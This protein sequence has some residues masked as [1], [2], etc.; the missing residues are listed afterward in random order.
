M[1]LYEGT[2][3]R[4]AEGIADPGFVDRCAERFAARHGCPPTVGERR[5]WERSWPRLLRALSA[6]GLGGLQLMLEYELPG[7]SQ[8][9]DALLLGESPAGDRLVAVVIELKQWTHAEPRREIPD[10]LIV[11]GRTVLHPGRQVGGYVNYLQDWLPAELGLEV[12]GLAYLHDA[13]TALIKKMRAQVSTGP[14]AGFPL[15]GEESVPLDEAP[16]VLAARFQSQDL[17]PAD[18][19]RIND[20]L[21]ARHRPSRD[22]L[23]K[24]AA[25]ISGDETF[26]LVDEQDRAR[27]EILHAITSMKQGKRGHIV[28]VTGGPG[29]GKTAIATRLFADLCRAEE[30][31]ANPRLLSPS[32][33]LSQQLARAAGDSARGLIRTLT[34][35]VPMGLDENTSVVLLDE[36][37]RARTDLTTRTT[38]FPNLFIRLLRR[39]AVLVLFLDEGQIVRPREGTT[40]RELQQ[41]ATRHEFTFAHIDLRAQFRCGG[42]QRYLDWVDALLSPG[43][44][45]TVW[46]GSE[47]YDLAIAPNPLELELWV[48]DHL[49]KGRLARITAGFCWPWDS[50]AD[51]PLEREVS[52]PWND[53]DGQHM[54]ERSWNS[55]ADRAL[56]DGTP[57]RAFWATDEG[58]HEQIGCVYTAQGMEYDYS[59][60]IF[61]EDLTWTAG[62]WQARPEKSHDPALQALSPEQYLPY[63]LNAYRV[64]ATRG[65]RGTRLYSTDPD[66]Q[67]LLQSL[68][69]NRPTQSDGHF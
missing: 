57:G 1:H 42:S 46:P 34:D 4:A 12:R 58:G 41:L 2:V 27:R 62:G 63:A 8:R 16:E 30:E 44:R 67:R 52:I 43:A 3:A 5:S 69:P 7:T 53:H 24:L 68:I 20:F 64:L 45:P 9:I 23:S 48:G 47:D 14:S 18:P 49:T 10:E 37:H 29:T 28:V 50:P 32:G 25:V 40:R 35:T 15:L 54:W 39:C 51:P 17:R 13:P 6:A 33:T 60:V 56:A 26:R 19:Q 11:A 38:E 61:G 22:L 65:T 55:R 36:A 59:A 21:E 66:T 31:G